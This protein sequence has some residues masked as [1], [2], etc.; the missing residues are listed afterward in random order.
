MGGGSSN[1]L[2]APGGGTAPGSSGPGAQQSRVPDQ[3]TGTGASANCG[4]ATAP[5]GTGMGDRGTSQGTRVPYGP[6]QSPVQGGPP[7]TSPT[8]RPLDLPEEGR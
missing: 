3:C 4:A 5:T 1:V 6:G 8:G 7:F 2:G